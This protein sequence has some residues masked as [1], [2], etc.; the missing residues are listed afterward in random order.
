V[1]DD[2]NDDDDDIFNCNCVDTQ[3]QQYSA[4]LHTNNAQNN[5]MS[6]NIQN[7]TYITIRILKLIKQHIT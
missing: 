7:G 6:Q 3:W 2:D 4:H 5:T 1:N